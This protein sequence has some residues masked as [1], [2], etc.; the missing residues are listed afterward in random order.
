MSP[1]S[2]VKSSAG[3]VLVKVFQVMAKDLPVTAALA[4]WSGLDHGA[5][6]S[7]RSVVVSYESDVITE[8][9][10]GN[11]PDNVFPVSVRLLQTFS[12]TVTP[13]CTNLVRPPTVSESPA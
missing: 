6:L 3:R 9:V 5:R 11:W 13:S 2:V 10:S 8:I 7:P 12:G 1:V 4:P